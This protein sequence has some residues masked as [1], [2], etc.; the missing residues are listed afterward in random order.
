M[1]YDYDA[2]TFA[3][4]NRNI[5]Y[6]VVVSAIERA[7]AERG[8]TQKQI[9]ERIGRR[10]SQVSMW[11]SGPSNWTLDT[12]SDL[13]RGIGA[14][15]NYTVTFDSDQIRSNVY[16]SASA[17]PMSLVNTTSSVAFN[18]QTAI[19]TSSGVLSS[20]ITPAPGIVKYGR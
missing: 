10:P 18:P 12:V 3:A 20:I 15:M 9:S 2:A 4:R 16:H 5:V 13:L 17:I 8:V 7:A 14:T 11:L 6:E 19:T 1:S